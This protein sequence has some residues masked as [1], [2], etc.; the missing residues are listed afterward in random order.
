M[1]ISFKAVGF[2]YSG[3]IAGMPGSEFNKKVIALLGVTQDTFHDVYFKFNH[4]IN[5]NILSRKDFWKKITEELDVPEKYDN[6]IKFI[7][8]LP[9]H[10]LNEQVL[11]LVDILKASGYKVGLLSNNDIAAANRFQETGLSKH[12]DAVVV[13]AEIGYSK[14]HP[15]AFEIFI[16]RL[17]VTASELI[18]IDDTEKSLVNAKAIGFQPILFTDYE[19]LVHNLKSLGIKTE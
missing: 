8:E 12:F 13:S 17:G 14:P 10:E 7:E 1:N 4:L 5:N 3:V 9:Q 16:E 15:K 19:S 18:Y 11:N 6:V 2:D